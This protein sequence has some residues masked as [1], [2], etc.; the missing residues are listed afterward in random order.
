MANEI[1]RAGIKVRDGA[2]GGHDVI[3][4]FCSDRPFINVNKVESI[5]RAVHEHRTARH[6]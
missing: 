4:T 5:D 3:C 1:S 6:S 2:F